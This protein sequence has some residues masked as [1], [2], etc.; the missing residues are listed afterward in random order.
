MAENTKSTETTTTFTDDLESIRCVLRSDD[1]LQIQQSGDYEQV[2]I[3]LDHDIQISFLF[4]SLQI[5]SQSLT[6]DNVLELRISKGSSKCPLNQEQ[7]AD[8]RKY[9]DELIRKADKTTSLRSIIQLIQDQ[10]LR[11]KITNPRF[12]P[13]EKKSNDDS[14]S[15]DN[16]SVSNKFRGGDLIFNRLLHDKTVDRGQVVI[17]YEDRFT[18]IHEIAFNEFKKVHDH[19]YGVPMH[20]LRYFKINGRT[21]W[22]RTKKL[23]ILTGSEQEDRI[24]NGVD[25]EMPLIQGL[26]RFEPLLE[27][28]VQQPHISLISDDTRTPSTND[29]C[30][31]QQCQFLTWNILFDYHHSSLIYTTQRYQS[32]LQTLKSLQPDLICLQEVT[33]TFLNLLLNE[34]WLQENN[35]Y[36]IIKQSII[37]SEQN[38][39]YGQLILMKNFRPRSFTICPLDISKNNDNTTTE[40]T[41][42]NA[43]KEIIIARFGLSTKVTIDIV[44]LHLHSNRSRNANDKRCQTLENLFKQ[45]NTK[46]YMLIGDFNFGDYD[47]KEQNMLEKYSNDIHDL[48]KDT[49]DIEQNPGFTYD[50]SR[51]ICARITSDTQINRRFD[52]YLIHTLYNLYYSIQHL[53][54]IG[55]DTIPIDPMNNDDDKRINQSDHYGLQLLINFQTRAIS[56]RSA[57]V[58]LP[59]TEHWP[60]IEEYREKYDPSF[61][62]WPPHI[63]ILWPFFDLTGCEDDEENILV[64]LRML[65]SHCESFNAEVNQIDTFI[66]NNISFMKL[67]DKSKDNVKN[68]YEQI[69]NLFPQ[70]CTNKRNSYNPHMTIAQFENE[71][72]R[73]EAQSTLTLNKPFE[74]PVQYLYI[75]QRSLDDDTTPF[76]ITY[77]LPLGSVLQPLH[78]QQLNRFNPKLQQFFQTMNLYENEQSYIRKQDKLNKLASCFD[79]MFN[80]DS[81]HCFTHE[82]L[83]YGSF[84]IGING[85]DLDTVFVLNE[86]KSNDEKTNFDE[87]LLEM[88]NKPNGMSNHIVNLLEMQINGCL[89]DEIFYSRKIE[90]LFPI[91]LIVFNDM[92]K[93]EIS[94]QVP[95]NKEQHGDE[96]RSENASNYDK[97]INGVHDIEHLLVHVRSPPIFQHLLTFIRNWAQHVGIYGQAFGYLG[98]YSWAVL[99]AYICRSFLSSIKSLSS[100]EQFSI[101]NFF[102]LVEKFFSTYANFNWTSEVV[103]LH[104]TSYKQTT[105][106][107]QKS[108]YNRG[109]MRILSPISPYNNTGRTTTN[110]TRDLIIQEFQ[111]VVD[112]LNR[113]NTITTKD[114]ANALKLVLE[115][116]NDFPN[117]TVQ[118]LLQLTLSCEN[119]N[120]L[121]EWIG[122][123]KSRLAHFMNGMENECHLIIQTQS[124]I[125]YQS[126]NTEAL[127]SIGFQLNQELISQKRNFTYFLDKLL[128]QFN[129]YPNRKETMKISYKLIGI[130]DWKLVRMQPKPQRTRK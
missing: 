43:T 72:Q 26:Y 116:N 69:K 60:L 34:M 119:V 79:Q 46:N 90:A 22:D 2:R 28:W 42:T 114:K 24:S 94:V 11:T 100:I 78:S 64:P 3:K 30:L 80:K 41:N 102:S 84:R 27:Q 83:S 56:H 10:L 17:G 18:G 15:A 32:I 107:E 101:D 130:H 123:L 111:R 91:I 129:Q 13:K 92:T 6:I 86:I 97:Y 68:L 87:T 127:Y 5:V 1:H 63:N 44:N 124:S 74:F 105:H 117:Q 95:T 77:Q 33:R 61:N 82:F 38:K 45:F 71:G 35:Y 21:V 58:V 23:D 108:M 89:K 40:I 20:R 31:P 103:R 66:E 109:T 52:R 37:N 122:W 106:S 59:T 54:M 70:C 29:T 49:Y 96:K 36:I 19:E 120:D 88:K 57:L 76:Q 110:S 53:N 121:D 67:N 14:A 25:Q 99:C 81:L 112:L 128:D 9:F 51:N 50:P 126:N 55:I 48:W 98:G 62:R 85:Q 4:D 93:V 118:S 7:W 104:S 16:A 125:E 47:V 12:K 115:L 73:N 8:I 113:V 75:L 39:S 65:L